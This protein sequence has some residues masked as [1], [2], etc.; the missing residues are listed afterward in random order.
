MN[1]RM[2]SITTHERDSGGSS[3][4]ST[5]IRPNG[6]S[7][8]MSSAPRGGKKPASTLLPSSGGIGK[9]LKTMSNT[10]KYMPAVQ[11]RMIQSSCAA[12]AMIAEAPNITATRYANVQ[13]V[14]MAR[15]DPGPAAATSTMSRFGLRRL[16]YCTGTG[17]AQPKYHCPP[18]MNAKPR[19]TMTVPSGSTCLSGFNDN[20]P[21]FCAVGSPSCFAAQ[22]CATSCSVIAKTIGIARMETISRTTL[23]SKPNTG[24]LYG[25]GRR[26]Q[27]PNAETSPLPLR[28]TA[29]SPPLRSSVDVALEPIA[30]LLGLRQRQGIR[31]Q[32]QRR[33]HQRLAER[34]EQRL[35]DRVIGHADPDGA[36]L[37]ILQPLRQLMGRAQHE[38][39]RPRRQSLVLPIRPVLDARI[40]GD[41]RQ[42][43]A[44]EREI[45]I[46]L[47]AAQPAHALERV[48]V[49]D[50]PAERVSRIRGIHDEPAG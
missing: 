50:V 31:R 5:M 48:L 23:R 6:S 2:P 35:R 37:R 22:P 11:T 12:P 41:V 7:R 13:P 27:P 25:V 32:Q 47:D 38:R 21:R 39:V 49:A 40:G 45:M 42:I 24:A 1:G 3:K 33:A 29:T 43:A 30:N 17:F 28:T 44:R 36:F 10:L 16:P 18:V 8:W 14:A 4:T 19:G 34:G 46:A 20:R 26:G 9:R 15:F